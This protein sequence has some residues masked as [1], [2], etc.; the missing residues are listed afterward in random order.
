MARFYRPRDGTRVG[1]GW[2]ACVHPDDLGHVLYE[3][4]ASCATRMECLLEFRLRRAD[5][6]Y[7]SMSYSSAPRFTPDGA[8]AGYIG[9]AADITELRRTQG[10]ALAMQ[11]LESLGLLAG[12]I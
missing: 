12:G 5:G 9:S 11:K 1:E 7:R 3:L 6:E 10:E 8:F 4:A 2:T